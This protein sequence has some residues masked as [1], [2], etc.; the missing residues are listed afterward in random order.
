MSWGLDAWVW[1]FLLREMTRLRIYWTLG[2]L[3]ANGSR[4]FG[5]GLS[6]QYLYPTSCH[7]SVAKAINP[8]ESCHITWQWDHKE[9][10]GFEEGESKGT[11]SESTWNKFL[12]LFQYALVNWWPYTTLV[13]R[14]YGLGKDQPLE[15]NKSLH[16]LREREIP[17]AGAPM[18]TSG[19]CQFS[20]TL[21]KHRLV[22]SLTLCTQF[23]TIYIH[24]IDMLV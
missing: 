1:F 24:R 4:S 15:C 3:Q 11:N 21:E 17:C 8:I 13:I 22:P 23:I 16:A 5:S 20:D 7:A 18:R 2:C 14:H 6:H 19:E 9:G 10:Q 12:S